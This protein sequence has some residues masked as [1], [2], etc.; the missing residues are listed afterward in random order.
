M[1]DR[2][3]RM[4][5]TSA[6][7]ALIAAVLMLVLVPAS[8]SAWTVTI[9]V[10]GAG[11]VLEVNNRFDDNQDQMNCLVGPDGRSN[12]SVT[13][14]VGGSAN[15]LYNSG[16]IVR[17]APQLS[18]AAVNRGWHFDHWTDSNAGGGLINC[19]PQNTAGDFSSP[20]YCEF[21]I[22]ENLRADLWFKDT[23]G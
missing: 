7:K 13:D 6:G 23:A 4:A 19:D 18:Q 9:H 15:G 21:Q 3:T 17:L 20:D 11:G 14:C 2:E 8:A 12:S 22:F 5:G 10:H 16:N 1:Q